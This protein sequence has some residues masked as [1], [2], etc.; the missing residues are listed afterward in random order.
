VAEA[1]CDT[2]DRLRPDPRGPRR[3]LIAFVEDRPGH[4]WRY[5]M[6]PSR[7]E[8]ALGWKAR[9]NFEAGL[10]ETLTWYLENESWW[11]GVRD[12]TYSGERLGV[13]RAAAAH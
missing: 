13:A 11:R 3:R 1:I 2:L 9:R 6:D 12:R 10:E 8:Q 7:A 4:D 5:A